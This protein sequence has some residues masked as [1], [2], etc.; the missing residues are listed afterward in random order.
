MGL[1]LNSFTIYD[2]ILQVETWFA[3]NFISVHVKARAKVRGFSG[4]LPSTLNLNICHGL[5]RC[6][7][8]RNSDMSVS[9]AWQ[10][11][12]AQC[13]RIAAGVGCHSRQHKSLASVP[14]LYK[15]AGIGFSTRNTASSVV[16]RLLS[17]SPCLP[18]HLVIDDKG[19]SRQSHLQII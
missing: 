9:I 7:S 19:A 6:A 16:F 4:G 10:A 14:I 5:T 15:S 12:I 3:C 1:R 13:A 18:V 2:S 8:I 17:L 11:C